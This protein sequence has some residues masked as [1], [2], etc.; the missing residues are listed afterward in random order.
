MR[1][2]VLIA[3]MFAAVT[4]LP[5]QADFFQCVPGPQCNGSPNNDLMNGSPGPNVMSGGAGNDLMIG[6]IGKDRLLGDDGDDLI[7]GGLDSD[8]IE[9]DAGNDTIVPGPDDAED[10]SLLAGTDGNDT[11]IVL[12]GETINC[13]LINGGPDFDALHLIGFGPY[14]ADFPYGLPEPVATSLLVIQ[15]PVAGG[16]LFVFVGSVGS[17]TERINGL[18]SLNFL[19]LDIPAYEA[20]AT[21][22]CTGFDFS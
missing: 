18:P 13:R 6:G 20:F 1:K 12:A 22:N 4:A 5:I 9:G 2:L 19:V 14:A 11:F 17:S 10:P 8:I 15:D 21:Q 7:F 3:M 16:Y